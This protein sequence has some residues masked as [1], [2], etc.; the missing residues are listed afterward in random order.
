[1][2]YHDI[3]A[4]KPLT[5]NGPEEIMKVLNEIAL[6]G[7]GFTTENLLESALDAGF[8]EPIYLSAS[9]EDPEAFYQGKAPAWATY[10][11]REW[12]RVFMVSVGSSGERR[13]RITETP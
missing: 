1:M 3:S 7:R 4:M 2:W 12:K 6:K 10:Q 13:F 5:L 8:T 11:I 9:G